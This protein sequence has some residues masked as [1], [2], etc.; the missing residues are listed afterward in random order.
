MQA[1]GF[2]ELAREGKRG[3]RGVGPRE[4]KRGCRARF[5]RDKGKWIWKLEGTKKQLSRDVRIRDENAQGGVIFFFFFLRRKR[6][7]RR[8][9]AEWLRLN[10]EDLLSLPHFTV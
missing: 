3:Q 8:D 4:E 2:A 7:V 5:V 10:N 9:T 1:R 6:F